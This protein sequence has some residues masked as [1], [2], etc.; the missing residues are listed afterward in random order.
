MDPELLE[1]EVRHT[2]GE[3][4]KSRMCS[5]SGIGTGNLVRFEQRLYIATC[6]HVADAYF[7]HNRPYI[8]LRGNTRIHSD[9]LEYVVRTNK[10]IDIA[11]IEVKSEHPHLTA[12]ELDNFEI[13]SRAI[14]IR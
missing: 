2:L 4:A 9:Q 14:I 7:H 11:L 1:K 12:Y 13:S 6:R 8:V 5:M 3:Y 10:Q